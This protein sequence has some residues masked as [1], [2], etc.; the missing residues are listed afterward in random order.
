MVNIITPYI[1]ANNI[2]FFCVCFL[3]LLCCVY[4]NVLAWYCWINYMDF[5][6]IQRYT[7]PQCLKLWVCL[8]IYSDLSIIKNVRS[9]CK[10]LR[11]I[12]EICAIKSCAIVNIYI[13][14][15]ITVKHINCINLYIFW[16]Y[17]C[18]NNITILYRIIT[19]ELNLCGKIYIWKSVVCCKIICTILWNWV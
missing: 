19:S 14:A 11:E 16:W 4:R 10:F 2:Y 15:I 13:C 9:I 1:I 7:L 12:I 8:K 18:N 3:G 5:V 6:D 17:N